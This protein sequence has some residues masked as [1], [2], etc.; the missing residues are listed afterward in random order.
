MLERKA[1]GR[2]LGLSLRMLAVVATTLLLY[3]A[4]LGGV[5]LGL[6]T[7][8]AATWWL[9][10]LLALVVAGTWL[11]LAYAQRLIVRIVRGR[12]ISRDR[13]LPGD[14]LL[15]EAVARLS[16]VADIP[17][18][19]IV[20]LREVAPKAS[21]PRARR[22]RRRRRTVA[23]KGAAPNAFS[24]GR[25]GNSAI[26]VT[27]SL[28]DRLNLAELEAVI[29]H[30]LTHVANRDALVVAAPGLFRVVGRALRA[31]CLAL[32]R[33]APNVVTEY[34]EGVWT[35]LPSDGATRRLGF[36]VLVF[37]LGTAVLAQ[38]LLPLALTLEAIGTLLTLTVSRYREYV[39]DRGS[40]L[41]T[42]APEQLMSALQKLSGDAD[43]I[44]KD[45]LRRLAGVNA[46]LI[47]SVPGGSS[48]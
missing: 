44:P 7:Y 28:L 32:A 1:V 36:G 38:A 11:H 16:G 27:E 25:P 48:C 10:L 33:D 35:G 46:L 9:W 3:L 37:S 18:P 5:A 39:A 21:S 40:A 6:T 8:G 20:L 14:R 17:Q 19:R 24:L 30:E 12:E 43:L 22:R 15:L 31:F 2:D 45:D 42:G 4:M 26:V 23:V 34:F 41:L 13:M 47:V 29:A